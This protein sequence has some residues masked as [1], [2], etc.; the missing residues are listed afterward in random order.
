MGASPAIIPELPKNLDKYY[1][2]WSKEQGQQLL[3]EDSLLA[4]KIIKSFDKKS[5]RQS[6]LAKI[7]G[8]TLVGGGKVYLNH[9]E[10]A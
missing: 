10:F 6:K 8:A 9:Q 3:Y 5:Q 4:K 2:R 7:A 1:P